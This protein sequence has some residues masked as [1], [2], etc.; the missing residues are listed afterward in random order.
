MGNKIPCKVTVR[1][2]DLERY[3]QALEKAGAKD[4]TTKL[5]LGEKGIPIFPMR[6]NI[7]FNAYELN[8]EEY[9]KRTFN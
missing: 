4:I 6:Y 7:H 1:T 9:R 3:V 8:W 5:L 2:E